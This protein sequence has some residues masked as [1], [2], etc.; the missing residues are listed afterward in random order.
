MV[1]LSLTAGCLVDNKLSQAKAARNG[2]CMEGRWK[3]HRDDGISKWQ[4]TAIETRL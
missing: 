4:G 3:V 2:S 1:L